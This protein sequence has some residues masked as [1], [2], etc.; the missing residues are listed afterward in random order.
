LLG[1]TGTVLLV[2]VGAAVVLRRRLVRLHSRLE[3]EL[4]REFQRASHATAN[5]AWL[6]ALP[7]ATSD[8]KLDIDE[9]ALP[10]DSALAG[11]TLGELA[12]RSRFGCSVVGIDR[13]G[14]GIAN[15][16]ADT[17]LFPRDKL[18]LLGTAEQLAEA[19]RHLTA[20][21]TPGQPTADFDEL[22]MESVRVPEGCPLAGRPLRELDLIRRAG[23]QV[24]GIRRGKQRNLAPSGEDRFESGDE[25]LLLGTHAQIKQLFTLLAPPGDPGASS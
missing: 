8:W 21:A 23:V 12:I 22:T 13:Q 17:V 9:V 25:L 16:R 5:S 1:V 2:L 20:A 19:T 11:R 6:V 4:R 24:G 18:L 14:Y 15:P 7:D 10:S 3:Y